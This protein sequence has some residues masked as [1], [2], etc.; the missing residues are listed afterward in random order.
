MIRTLV[1]FLFLIALGAQLKAQNKNYFLIDKEVDTTEMHERDLKYLREGLDLFQKEKDPLKKIKALSEMLDQLYDERYWVEYADYLFDYVEK[2][3]KSEQDPKRKKELK[4]YYAFSYL[5]KGYYTDIIGNYKD[6][7]KL[8]RICLK[9]FTELNDEEN[10]ATS[11]NN[12][13]FTFKEEGNLDSALFYF[14]ESIKWNVENEEEHS[15]HFN[16]IGYIYDLKGDIISAYEY[17][18]KARK[19][20]EKDPGR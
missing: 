1:L 13:G 12:I 16:N 6:S 5:N 15:V 18:D 14:K 19:I 7:R 8:Y 3:F 4:K 20:Q 17:Y 10:V 11:L 2:E 9:M